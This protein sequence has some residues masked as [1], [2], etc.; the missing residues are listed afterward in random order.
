MP[1]RVEKEIV[2]FYLCACDVKISIKLLE[3]GS[4]QGVCVPDT[5]VFSESIRPRALLTNI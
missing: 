5:S 3:R 4:A 2:F 1:R